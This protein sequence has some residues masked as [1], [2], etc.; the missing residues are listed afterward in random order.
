MKRMSII[1]GTNGKLNFCVNLDV[2]CPENRYK[3]RRRPFANQD[4]KEMVT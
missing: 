2:R 1:S 4:E 3:K